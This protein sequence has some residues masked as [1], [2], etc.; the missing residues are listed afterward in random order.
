MSEIERPTDA[1][2][3]TAFGAGD[4]DVFAGIYDRYADRIYSYCLTMLRNPDDAA[5]AAH[6]VFVETT[7]WL[8]QLRDPSKLR[9]WLFAV[10][11]NEAHGKGRQRARVTPEEDLSKTL[12]IEPDLATGPKLAEL[13]ELV[14]DAAAG[15]GERDQQLLALHLTEGLEGGDLAEA[16]GVETTHLPV[17]VSRMKERVE[18]ALGALLIARLGNEDCM[19]LQTLLANWDGTFDMEVRSWVTRHVEGCELCQKR[20]AFLLAPANVLPS[21]LVVPAPVALRDRVFGSTGEPLSLFSEG[22]EWMKFAMFAVV[23]LVMGVIGIAVSGQFEPIEPSPTVAGPVP[24][25]G[26]STTTTTASASTTTAAGDT[27]TSTVGEAAPASIEVST[28]T[29]DFGDDAT[30]VVFDL[31]NSGQ[32]PGEWAIES[33]TEA[34][35]VSTGSGELAPG[36][37]LTIELSLD[38]SLIEEG[39]LSETISVTWSGGEA[40]VTAVGTHEDNPIIHNP[41]ASPSEVRVEGDAACSPTQTTISARIRD[42]SPIESVVIRWSPDGSGSQETSMVPVGNDIFEGVIGPF[43]AAQAA[44]VRVVAFDDRGNAGGATLTVNVIACP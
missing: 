27:T 2:L 37:S 23:A 6:D 11:R 20:R 7:T 18:K 32:Q 22:G 39:D 26:N 41:Q 40:V 21:I 44:S 10:A 31:V 15:L 4:G 35:S 28:D 19:E 25:A 38:R 3:V 8:E 30:A 33:S 1:E 17:M 29:V 5:D 43:S 42:T 9:P 14:W 34:I 16:M 36:E 24:V 13:R 12:V